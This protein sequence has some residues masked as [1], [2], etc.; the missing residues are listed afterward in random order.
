M[1]PKVSVIIPTYNRADLLPRTIKSSL[2]QTFKDFELIIVD[3]GST[4]NTKEVVEKFK[5]KDNRVKYIWQENSGGPAS[6]KNK[7]IKAS[8]G[9]Y[10]AFLDDDDEWFPEKIEKQLEIFEN[11]KVKNIGIVA[12]N[13]LD[14]FEDSKT[15]KEYKIKETKEEKYLPMILNGCFIHSSSSVVVKK[16][17]FKKV[18][19]FDKRLKTADDWDMWIRIISK[20]NFDF[21]PHPLFKYCIHGE[22]ISWN[23]STFLKVE[24][25][26]FIFKKNKKVYR[27]YPNIYC[28]KLKEITKLFLLNR[29]L[30]EAR[31]CTMRAIK[32]NPFILKN[33]FH[34]FFTFLPRN[35]YK[36]LIIFKRKITGNP[37][38]EI[39]K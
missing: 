12:C 32:I 38:I 14:L 21:Y 22:N 31:E 33:Y 17:T 19:Y 13:A 11:S 15:T 29:N 4:D 3:D 9:E 2:N 25:L 5:K 34:L 7:G 37:N 28:K 10:I 16:N 23:K 30:K 36:N 18:G 8:K 20:Y 35:T 24:E 1:D 39:I 26:S 6:P 27:K